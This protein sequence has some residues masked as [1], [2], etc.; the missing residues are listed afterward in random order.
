MASGKNCPVKDSDDADELP[1]LSGK[2]DAKKKVKKAR[3]IVY[4]DG[5]NL[6]HGAVKGTSEKWLDLQT[7]FE[8]LRGQ[9]EIVQVHYFTA[10]VNGDARRRQE[11]FLRALCTL[12]KVNVI[13]GRYKTKRVTCRTTDCCHTGDRRFVT[14]EEKR[15]D[16]NIAVQMMDDAYR[17][18]CDTFVVVSGDSDLV[19]P[20]LRIKERFPQKKVVV[21]IPARDTTRGA[22][23]EMRAAADRDAT[24]PLD[25]LKKCQ[26]PARLADGAGGFIEKPSEW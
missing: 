24:L 17:D 18:L 26:L 8:R 9:D 15:T 3:V 25:L 21:Y 4:V 1:I 14:W 7:Y 5:F 10:R 12:P 23:T 2:I 22:A 11:T 6:Y 13:E 19:P 20:I 16:V